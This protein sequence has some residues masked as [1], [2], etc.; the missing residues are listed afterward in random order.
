VTSSGRVRPFF[1][2]FADSVEYGP[3]HGYTLF[4]RNGQE[5]AFP[6]GYGL[7][8]TTYA[9]TNLKVAT[10]TV[11]ADGPVEVTVDVTN[12][13]TRAGEEIVQLY[14]EFEG[15]KVERPAKLLRA[16][17]KI[18]LES[19][20]TKTVPLS[21]AVKELAWYNVETKGWEIEPAT[22]G[23]LVGPSSRG[24]DLL[25]ASFSVETAPAR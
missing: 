18:A 11:P 6:F 2:E 14:V 13:G 8:Y 12:T 25:K 16:F 5:P 23:V 20:E 21:V 1:D 3:Y 4:D 22:Y 24:T 7:S 10:P 17:R 15:A 9:Y 19:G